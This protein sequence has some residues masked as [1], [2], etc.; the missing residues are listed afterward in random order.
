MVAYD[1]FCHKIT[2]F[3][4]RQPGQQVEI[5]GLVD[6]LRKIGYFR[7]FRVSENGAF[8]TEKDTKRHGRKLKRHRKAAYRRVRKYYKSVRQYKK[9]RLRRKLCWLLSGKYRETEI[10]DM[11][12]ISVRTVIRD[13]NK[14][15]PYYVRMSRAYFNRMEQDRIKEMNLKLEG[16]SLF[17]RLDILTTAMIEWRKRFKLRPYRRHY[18]IITIDMTQQKNVIPKITFSGGKRSTLAFPHKI[19]IHVKAVHEGRE[20]TTDVAG[21]ELTQTTEGLW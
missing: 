13:I 7:S 9:E 21:I 3:P 1:E 6:A 19:R 18:Q 16:K 17:E 20:F 2:H 15:K 11:L 5:L 14:I 12:G 8:D 4:F 10:A